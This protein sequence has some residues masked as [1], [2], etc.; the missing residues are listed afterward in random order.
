FQQAKLLA[1]EDAQVKADLKI[2][3]TLKGGKLTRLQLLQQLDKANRK[4]VKIESKNGQVRLTKGELVAFQGKAAEQLQVQPQ[5]DGPPKGAK[6]EMAEQDLLKAHKDRQRVAELKL[7]DGVE[8][9]LRQARKLLAS[10]PDA[11]YEAVRSALVRVRDHPDLAEGLRERLL[12][13]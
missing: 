13:D 10:D 3:D 12:R 5:A 6:E 9:S 1:P 2:L 11:A 4:A 7:Q 8:A